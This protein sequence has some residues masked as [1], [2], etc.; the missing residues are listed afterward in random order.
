MSKTNLSMTLPK[1]GDKLFRIMS[2]GR[3]DP[4]DA[5]NPEPCTVEY[6]NEKKGWYEVCFDETNIKECY[7]VPS[8]DHRF[9]KDKPVGGVPIACLE[10][11]NIYGSIAECARDMK[12]NKHEIWK[13]I[14]GRRA[15]CSGYHFVTVL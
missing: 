8:F 12:L 2:R 3:Y 7:R 4:G 11:G 1:V 15:Y 5:Y 9:L 13:Q 14:D 6:V 10:T